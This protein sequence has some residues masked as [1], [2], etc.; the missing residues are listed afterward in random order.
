VR[1][2]AAIAGLQFAIW[3]AAI[4]TGV[5]ILRAIQRYRRE[6]TLRS[7]LM[8]FAPVAA[9]SAHDPRHLLA[10]YPI[11]AAT[12]KLFPDAFRELDAA[13]GSPFPF[14]KEHLQAAHARCTAAWLAWERTHDAEYALKTAELED[15]RARTPGR[16]A[17][18]NARLSALE[19]EKLETYQQRYQEYVE[20]SKAL[21]ALIE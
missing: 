12:R 5:L 18:L 21:K 19:R 11:A 3:T 15:E 13:V 4:V 6:A 9:A 17:L 8:T 10:W 20:T 16:S 2:V 1:V 14:T 7:V